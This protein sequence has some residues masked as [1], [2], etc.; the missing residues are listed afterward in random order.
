MKYKY[1][2]QTRENENREGWIHAKNRADAYAQLRRQGVKPYRLIG[3]DPVEW[4]PWAIGAAF[5]ALISAVVVLASRAGDDRRA[6]TVPLARRQLTGDRKE[7]SRG[8]ET[9]WSGVFRTGLDRHLAA[10]AQP[11]WLAI[12]P[13]RGG[14]FEKRFA[15]DLGTPLEFS[16][17]DGEVA[18]QM[19]RIVLSMR[20]ELSRYLES[21]GTIGEYLDFLDGRLGEEIDFRRKAEASIETAPP[22]MRE[23]VRAN[24]NMRLRD[25]G[26]SEL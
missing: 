21:G 19:K 5:A 17:D 13:E 16:P 22:Q 9:S 25:M 4:R 3:D 26:M 12:P 23:R 24:V 15:E 1:L 11:G 6:E 14:D 18:S 10:Y 2:Y 20:N 7:I 8:L